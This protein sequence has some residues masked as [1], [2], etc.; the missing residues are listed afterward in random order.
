M[1]SIAYRDKRIRML[2]SELLRVPYV[3]YLRRY[4]STVLA[5]PAC[6]AKRNI[7]LVL[8]VLRLQIFTVLVAT[9]HLEF[10]AIMKL[11]YT[12]QFF[13]QCIGQGNRGQS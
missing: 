2:V 9:R 5:E 4:F 13:L 11:S 3:M 1:T 6:A 12:I 10:I 7:S 8:P